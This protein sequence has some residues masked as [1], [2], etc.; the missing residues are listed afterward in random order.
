ME[1]TPD[2]VWNSTLF[3]EGFRTVMSHGIPA[4]PD[5]AGNCFG[6]MQIVQANKDEFSWDLC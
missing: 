4:L 2:G 5:P 6:W 1:E 3:W